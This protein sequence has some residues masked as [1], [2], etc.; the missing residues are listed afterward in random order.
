MT[1]TASLSLLLGIILAISAQPTFTA[2]AQDNS[3]RTTTS[4]KGKTP[5]P[6]EKNEEQQPEQQNWA[7]D[8]DSRHRTC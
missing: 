3:L 1:N 8:F 6:I 2:K 4:D 5:I 7:I